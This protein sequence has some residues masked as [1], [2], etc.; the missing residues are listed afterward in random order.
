MDVSLS[1]W[2]LDQAR[3]ADEVK[4]Y[5]TLVDSFHVDVMD[6]RFADNLL[7]GPLT[8]EMLRALTGREIVVHL[9]VAEPGR[10]IN[11]FV[12]AGADVL[13]VHTSAC[14]DLPATLQQ[15]KKSGA[16]A[17]AAVGLKEQCSSIFDC[18]ADL[19]VVLVMATPIGVKGC[20]FD[21]LALPTVKDLVAARKAA[22]SPHVTVDGGI[23]WTSIPKIAAAGA[24]GV[25]AGSVVTSASRPSSAIAAIAAI[26]ARGP[27]SVDALVSLLQ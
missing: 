25:V 3:I 15:I 7:F 8:V 22:G 24:D 16:R 13:I 17:G 5:E 20:S 21:E 14:S 11:R 19:S 18:L 27:Q 4:R 10:W 9:M 1:L 26:G 12:E 2:S 23:R 6:G